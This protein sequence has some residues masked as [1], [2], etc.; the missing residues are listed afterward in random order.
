MPKTIAQVIFDRIEARERELNPLPQAWYDRPTLHDLYREVDG[1]MV[2]VSKG[3]LDYDKD[4]FVVPLKL[5]KM[6][7]HKRSD[8]LRY[9][10][11][12]GEIEW[13]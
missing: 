3:F 2:L 5:R 11:L 7:E 9:M 10:N 6:F 1:K 8:C 4:R 13:V 12:Y